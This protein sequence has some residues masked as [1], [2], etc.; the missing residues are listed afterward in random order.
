MT[1]V[2][3]FGEILLRLTPPGYDKFLQASRFCVSF[4][5]SETNVA[6]SLSHLGMQS[7]FVSRLPQNDIARMACMQLQKHGVMT[8]NMVVG[9]DRLGLYYYENTSAM[10]ASRVIYDRAESAYAT[11][12]PADY[13]WDQIFERSGADWFHWSGIGPSLS[14]S[15]A[16][17][18]RAAIDSARRHG[19]RIS[20]DLNYRKNLWNYGREPHEVMKPLCA[21]CDILFGT[22]VEYQKAFGIKPAVGFDMNSDTQE[23]E[24]AAHHDFAR[25][26][27]SLAP[28]CQKMFIAQ[29]KVFHA[30]HH[31][32]WAMLATSD[33]R[34]LQSDNYDIEPVVDCVGCG[35]AFAAGM[36]C[37]VCRYPDD[38][39]KALAFAT[40]AATL[41]NTIR[42][43]FNLSSA[44]EVLSL[45][46]GNTSGRIAR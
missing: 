22:E 37:G 16:D 28:K 34:F 31:S 5:G 46:S 4:G 26:I 23:I 9:G 21:E 17:A 13:D 12:S 18:T 7:E 33:G 8:N 29:R 43:D 39:S 19:L 27:L 40:A 14:Q 20:A 41:K 1:K 45:M 2:L 10:R 6:V 35:D 25:Q 30:K 15:A 44:D 32:F 36:I 11:S 38:D 42:G 24:A 3:T